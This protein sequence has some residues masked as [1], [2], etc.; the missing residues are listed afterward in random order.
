VRSSHLVWSKEKL[1]YNLKSLFIQYDGYWGYGNFNTTIHK[2][3]D[4]IPS[5]VENV[6]L[7]INNMW[8]IYLHGEKF[9]SVKRIYVDGYATI[10]LKGN[11]PALQIIVGNFIETKDAILPPN[12]FISAH[13][14]QFHYNGFPE[15]T[16][17]VNFVE[18]QKQF[19]SKQQFNNKHFLW[20]NETMK[21]NKFPILG[22]TQNAFFINLIF[23]DDINII[24][25]FYSKEVDYYPAHL[26]LYINFESLIKNDTHRFIE[27]LR[28]IG[29]LK[30][31]GK[32]YSIHII[33][34]T[35]S[36][37]KEKYKK[38]I[39]D[40][41][42]N[43]IPSVQEIFLK[44]KGFTRIRSKGKKILYLESND[45]TRTGLK[46]DVLA[47]ETLHPQSKDLGIIVSDFLDKKNN[48]TCIF[49]LSGLSILSYFLYVMYKK[50]DSRIL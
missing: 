10:I 12:V 31:F 14:L 26:I 30:N 22:I 46:A 41:I 6:C 16:D 47:N 1:T 39:T 48:V 13:Q 20:F 50:Y 37:N 19:L 28:K 11:F 18:S 2:I 49:I 7:I 29:S 17:Q 15:E 34:P 27:L 4:N 3:L 8:P 21:R 35:A 36:V 42:F 40:N 24:D 5:T 23:P 45:E 32:L 9:T 43:F 25:F 44:I 38:L 33:S